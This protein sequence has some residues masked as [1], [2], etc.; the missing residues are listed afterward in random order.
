MTRQL[1]IPADGFHV[2]ALAEEHERE[3]D[4]RPF[5]P[6]GL[7]A[8]KPDRLPH[9]AEKDFDTL[10]GVLERSGWIQVTAAMY[11]GKLYRMTREGIQAVWYGKTNGVTELQFGRAHTAP[12]I[13]VAQGA[14]GQVQANVNTGP[15]TIQ[16][17]QTNTIGASEQAEIL[18]L[19]HEL[20]RT[21]T[22]LPPSG[23]QQAAQNLA[24]SA[25]A[26]AEQSRWQE[27]GQR[28][29]ILLPTLGLIVGTVADAQPAIDTAA[30]VLH[31]LGLGT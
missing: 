24:D 2:L 5:T 29:S 12:V 18:S 6:G 27:V 10:F 1:D 14:T 23:D 21:I 17:T 8:W 31:A 19:L 26:A 30:R 11:A 16:A 3:T 15:G 25:T 13:H 28:M 4:G 7:Q 20:R 22:A 9:L